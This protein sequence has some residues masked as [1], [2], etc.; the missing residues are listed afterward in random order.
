[1]A[2]LSYRRDGAR[3]LSLRRSKPFKVNR[4]PAC[5][6]LLMNN[7]NLHPACTVY[8]LPRSSG[9]VITFDTGVL[10][11]SLSSV[12]SANIAISHIIL[13][14]DSVDYIFVADNMELYLTTLIQMGHTC[15]EFGGITQNNSHYA[16]E[17]HPRSLILVIVETS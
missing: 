8:Q 12:T 5:D 6:F 1:M 4:K 16:V 9:Q 3:R 11:H 7:T 10:M 14:I 15:A 17:G 13:K 2:E